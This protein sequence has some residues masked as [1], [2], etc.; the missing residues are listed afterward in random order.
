MSNA[1]ESFV[2]YLQEGNSVTTRQARTLF[3]VQNIADLVY[4]AR[5]AGLSVY[6]NRRYNSRGKKVFSYRLGTPSNQF[7]N[8]LMSGHLARARKTLYRQAIRVTMAA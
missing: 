7:V 8:Y 2:S 5:N 1:L 6:T 3:K 4:R